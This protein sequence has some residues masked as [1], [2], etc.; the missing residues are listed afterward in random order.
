MQ[1][2][3]S[4]TID[5]KKIVSKPFDFECMCLVNDM[6]NSVMRLDGSSKAGPLRL[7]KEAVS[8]M[9]EG[10]EVTDEVLKGLSVQQR[11]ALGLACWNIYLANFTNA[12][13]NGQGA[14][15]AEG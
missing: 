14:E 2:T 8:R 4:V 7:T 9:F 11:T 15:Q 10:T 1:N 12:P 5:G 13:K 3:I 6:H